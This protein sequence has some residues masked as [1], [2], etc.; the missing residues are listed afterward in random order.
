MATKGPL[1]KS[2]DEF[3]N[4]IVDYLKNNCSVK[5][6]HE[7]IENGLLFLEGTASIGRKLSPVALVGYPGSG[8]DIRDLP[9]PWQTEV[10]PIL[11]RFWSELSKKN[12]L[13]P[14]IILGHSFDEVF[15]RKVSLLRPAVKNIFM[16]QYINVWNINH[17]GD[18][19][20]QCGHHMENSLKKEAAIKNERHDLKSAIIEYLRIGNKL[21][22]FEYE[23]IGIEVPAGEGTKKSESIDILAL[24]RQRHWLTVIELKYEDIGRRRLE[25]SILQGLDYCRWVEENKRALAMLLPKHKIDTRRRTRL[26]LINGPKKFP[27]FYGD[28]IRSWQERDRYQEIELY[29]TNDRT[30]IT[31]SPVP[32]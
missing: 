28:F 11:F 25:S 32:E 14:L 30:P 3:I 12:E 7:K 6:N 24:E 16:I 19:L 9:T 22:Q 31:I 15:L 5:V 23:I 13:V 20:D 29:Y 27:T 8:K 17:L 10:L 26:I 18:Q 4:Y 1:M 21:G 2:R